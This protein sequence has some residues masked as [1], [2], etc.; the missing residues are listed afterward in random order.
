[1][2]TIID[3]I[4]GELSLGLQQPQDFNVEIQDSCSAFIWFWVD[5]SRDIL[6]SVRLTKTG[7][8][9]KNSHRTE[10]NQYS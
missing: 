2:K 8:V 7:K 6:N 1:M 10:Q 3:Q 5:G 4:K 9:A